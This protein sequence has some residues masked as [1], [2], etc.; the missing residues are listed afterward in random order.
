MQIKSKMYVI[1]EIDMK[2][3]KNVYDDTKLRIFVN[4]LS[5]TICIKRQHL[6]FC[7]TFNRHSMTRVNVA[8]QIMILGQ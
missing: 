1:W 6:V 2:N 5:Y 3:E 7:I 8:K 4:G